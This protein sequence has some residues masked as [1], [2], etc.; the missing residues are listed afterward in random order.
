MTS[1]PISTALQTFLAPGAASAHPSRPMPLPDVQMDAPLLKGLRVLAL[2]KRDAAAYSSQAQLLDRIEDL[3]FRCEHSFA[4]VNDLMD[5]IATEAVDV[6]LLPN[7]YGN[8]RRL[9]AYERCRD[10]AIPVVVFDRGGLPNSWF[11]DV[12]FNADSPSYSPMIWDRELNQDETAHVRQYISELKSSARALEEQAGRLGAAGAR[13][14]LGLEGKK[15]LF[16]PLQRP[17][18]TTIKYFSGSV[19]DLPDFMRKLKQLQTLLDEHGEQWVILCKKHPLETTAPASTLRFAPDDMHVN[20]LLELCDAV[21]L[22]NSGVGLLASLYDKPVYHFGRVYYGHPALNRRVTSADEV[23]AGLLRAP[24]EVSAE[25]RD[26]LIHHLITRVYSSAEFVTERVEQKDG[27]FRNITRHIDFHEL[28]LPDVRAWRGAS[29]RILYVTPVIPVPNN[30]GSAVRTDQVVRALRALGCQVDLMVLNRS[31]KG[32]SSFA[33]Q[34]RLQ[35]AYPGSRIEVRRHPSFDDGKGIPAR[36]RR[37]AHRARRARDIAKLQ[38]WGI[39]HEDECPGNFRSAVEKRLVS[40]KYDILYCNYLKIACGTDTGRK[41]HRIVD[42]HDVQT[43]RI[44]NDVA[45]SWHPL[46]RP[47][48]LK[49]FERSERELMSCFDSIVAITD[50]EQEIVQADYAPGKAVS[51]LP[52]TFSDAPRSAP[53]TGRSKDLLFIGSNSDANGASIVWFLR[54]VWPLV[55]AEQPQVQLTIQGRVVHNK[56]LGKLLEAGIVAEQDVS[57]GG[58]VPDLS[59]EYADAK[60]AISPTTHGTGMKV[61]VIEALQHG[62]A[63]VGT[64]VAFE[65]IHAVDSTHAMIADDARSFADKTLQLLRDPELRARVAAGARELYDAEHSFGVAVERLRTVLADA[66]YPPAGIGRT[67]GR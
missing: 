36:L 49:H 37:L 51:V 21:C 35:V 52:V 34:K 66:G 42:L 6:V 57:L 48:L 67:E 22:I 15:V 16:V 38:R 56:A 1:S 62:S 4:D 8:K 53:A 31:E 65:G 24:V 5:Y 63:L 39:Q 58:F 54:D 14:K 47:A 18:D 64:S 25:V 43:N 40:G 11:F 28:R 59:A 12:G 61:K 27:S 7:P 26:R 19:K 29:P 10:A 33:I 32:T 50:V 46:V 20:D 30:R 3:R 2:G 17:S 55:K 44:R 60:V 23:A 13:A 45:P 41:V 9:Y